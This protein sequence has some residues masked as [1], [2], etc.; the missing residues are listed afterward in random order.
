MLL[1]GCSETENQRET[2]IERILLKKGFGI[3][4]S[5]YMKTMMVNLTL[6]VISFCLWF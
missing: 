3:F 2:D 5:R 1:R 6:R 4:K